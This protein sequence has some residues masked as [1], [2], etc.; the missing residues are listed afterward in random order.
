[1]F[2]IWIRVYVYTELLMP[3]VVYRGWDAA[4]GCRVNEE[5]HLA[6]IIHTINNL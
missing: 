2:T 6:R 3:V 5:Y 4:G 1:M